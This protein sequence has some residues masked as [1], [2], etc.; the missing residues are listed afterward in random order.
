MKF[1]YPSGDTW[2]SLNLNRMHVVEEATAYVR[3]VD[4][5]DNKFK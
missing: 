3:Y 5:R 4:D 2:I 1:H